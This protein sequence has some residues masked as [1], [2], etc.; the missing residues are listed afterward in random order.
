MPD[1]VITGWTTGLDSARC[2]QLLQSAAGLSANDAKRAIE[3]LLHGET[4]R[5]PV[6]PGPDAAL[7]VAALGKLGAAAHVDPGSA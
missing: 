2:V 1:V 7:I 4:Q 5:V 6:R 3:R